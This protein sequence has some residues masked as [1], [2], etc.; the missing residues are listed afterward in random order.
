MISSVFPWRQWLGFTTTQDACVAKLVRAYEGSDGAE[1][2]VAHVNLR[3]R[4]HN[5]AEAPGALAGILRAL[6]QPNCEVPAGFAQ[7]SRRILGVAKNSGQLST[8]ATKPIEHAWRDLLATVRRQVKESCDAAAALHQAGDHQSADQQYAAAAHLWEE[9]V[10]IDDCRS[11]APRHAALQAHVAAHKFS[12]AANLLATSPQVLTAL[13]AQDL[14]LEGALC[15]LA[16][17]EVASSIGDQ[18]EA[19]LQIAEKRA[20]ADLHH[21]HLLRKARHKLRL[22]A[23]APTTSAGWSRRF[24]AIGGMPV[25]ALAQGLAWAKELETVAPHESS[26]NQMRLETLDRLPWG[27]GRAPCSDTPAVRMKHAKDKL[28]E[29]CWGL[30]EAKR[31][32][33]RYH[34]RTLRPNHQ[35]GKVLLLAGPPG[36]GKTTLISHGLGPALSMP[37]VRIPLGGKWDTLFLC[38]LEVGYGGS[39]IGAIVEALIKEQ[40]EEIIFFFDEVDKL[41]TQRSQALSHVLQNLT[42]AAYT[43]QFKDALLPTVDIDLSKCLF[44]FAC[45]DVA[46]IEASLLDRMEII[47]LSEPTRRDKV[48]AMRRYIVPKEIK[49]CGLEERDI[50]FDSAIIED[51][52]DRHSHTPGVRAS[53]Q[54][55]RRLISTVNESC[56]D[57]QLA[58]P[59]SLHLGQARQVALHESGSLARLDDLHGLAESATSMTELQRA[60]RDFTDVMPQV[61]TLCLANCNLTDADLIVICST[62]TTLSPQIVS[63]DIGGNC[64]TDVAPLSQLTSLTELYL[65]GNQISGLLSSLSSLRRLRSLELHDNKLAKAPGAL[66]KTL[67]HFKRLTLDNQLSQDGF[68]SACRVVWHKKRR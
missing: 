60:F 39:H 46:K 7:F 18:L 56:L 47:R 10:G 35:P 9:L 15:V 3:L 44:V 19:A 43:K 25:G 64:I 57:K 30:D 16:A 29:S 5:V 36:I 48:T 23:P 32:I 45:N 55:F 51:Q 66:L 49:A 59:V 58:F 63:L 6:N 11:L 22:R 61:R 14:G 21:L 2:A 24:E 54:A 37:V 42:D 38:G 12:L 27:I 17:Q 65:A 53:A 26:R 13:T 67:P 50:H 8:A 40:T 68:N 62:L 1:E 31:E 34:A 4:N 20:T 33:E 52:V 41:D 28:R